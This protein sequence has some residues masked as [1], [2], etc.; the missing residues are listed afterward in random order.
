MVEGL[1]KWDMDRFYK[2]LLE[3]YT[4]ALKEIF[5][6]ELTPEEKAS[7]K[8]ANGKTRKIGLSIVDSL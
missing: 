7:G 2:F 5:L 4:S 8:A 3:A 6:V 1:L